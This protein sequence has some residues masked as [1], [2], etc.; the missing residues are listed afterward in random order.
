MPDL[1]QTLLTR[2]AGAISRAQL[3]DAGFT[4]GQIRARVDGGRWQRAYDGVYVTFTGPMPRGTE[5]WAALLT[6]GAGAT[7]CRDTALELDALGDDRANTI[8]I[9]VPP[10]RRLRPPVGIRVFYEQHL[11]RHR[12]PTANPP[13]TR[14]EHSVLDVVHRSASPAEV[15]DVITRACQ[16]RRTTADRIARAAALRSRLRWRRLVHD[17]CADTADGAESALEVHYVRG[18]E[19][20][21]GLPHGERQ[22]ASRSGLRTRWRDVAYRAYGVVVELDGAATRPQEVAFRDYR[23]DNAAAVQREVALRYGWHDVAGAPCAVAAQVGLVLG[24]RGWPGRTRPCGPPCLV[25]VAA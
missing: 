21:H 7:F 9:A 16:R 25:R 2:Q 1:P 13:R 8:E 14:V 22:Q 5:L 19:R 17:V 24:Q 3:Q 12:H 23:R 18:V 15:I 6:C 20:P 4:P 10:S 11:D